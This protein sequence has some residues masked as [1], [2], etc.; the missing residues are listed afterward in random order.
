MEAAAVSEESVAEEVEAAV[1][2]KVAE[3]VEAAAVSEEVLLKV[4]VAAVSGEEVLLRKWRRTLFLLNW[5]ILR[6]KKNRRVVL[7]QVFLIWWS[8]IK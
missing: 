6:M 4:E 1:S 5:K 8:V 7:L 3:E 2:E